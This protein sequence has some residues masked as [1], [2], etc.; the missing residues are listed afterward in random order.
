MMRHGLSLQSL[1]GERVKG[2][3]RTPARP[4]R[5]RASFRLAPEYPLRGTRAGATMSG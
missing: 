5:G 3:G 4:F 1:A 2:S